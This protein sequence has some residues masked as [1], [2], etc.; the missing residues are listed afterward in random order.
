MKW[1]VADRSKI[2]FIMSDKKW[3]ASSHDSSCMNLP[4]KSVSI[5]FLDDNL[6]H[7]VLPSILSIGSDRI[8]SAL[9]TYTD[10]IFAL[11]NTILKVVKNADK[12]PI[13]SDFCIFSI[14]YSPFLSLNGS[15]L[16]DSNEKFDRWKDFDIDK[17]YPAWPA[18][19]KNDEIEVCFFFVWLMPLICFRGR[20]M[21]NVSCFGWKN[22]ISMKDFTTFKAH[23]TIQ[24][25]K[26]CSINIT[27]ESRT[28]H[29]DDGHFN[30]SPL[31]L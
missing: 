13:H 27:N 1:F 12:E 6:F 24:E 26:R 7:C 9:N 20:S 16:F 5:L 25:F 21:A 2:W 15:A 23:V 30:G 17:V 10:V 19:S 14:Q 11:H 3:L 8:V 28:F 31:F 4:T 18:N 29:I 22:R